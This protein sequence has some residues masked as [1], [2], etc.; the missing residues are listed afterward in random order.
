M[1]AS[2]F[3]LEFTEVWRFNRDLAR[4]IPTKVELINLI[5]IVPSVSYR[6]HISTQ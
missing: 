1:D 6:G 4:F 5:E 2:T 3:D